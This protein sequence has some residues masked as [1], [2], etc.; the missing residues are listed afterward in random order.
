MRLA[1]SDDVTPANAPLVPGWVT[2]ISVV[3][4]LCGHP[5]P[6]HE[7]AVLDR[8]DDFGQSTSVTAGELRDLAWPR[9]SRAC[10][11]ANAEDGS[12]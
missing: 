11:G 4:D 10:R 7:A 5:F 2:P 6:D 3:L 12:R 8:L 9:V 1:G